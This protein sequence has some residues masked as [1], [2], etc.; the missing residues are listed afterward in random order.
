MWVLGRGARP[1]V[2]AGARAQS[3]ALP[4]VWG[5][6]AGGCSATGHGAGKGR[7]S[8]AAAGAPPRRV[9][10]PA[11][12]R[13]GHGPGRVLRRG[14]GALARAGAPPRGAC[15]GKG[16]H[17]GAAAGAPH[18]RVGAPA[19][20]EGT[21]WGTQW[22]PDVCARVGLHGPRRYAVFF[23]LATER[24]NKFAINLKPTVLNSAMVTIA[25]SHPRFL[26]SKHPGGI[27]CMFADI[28][29]N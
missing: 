24:L 14:R 8:G 22:S 2:R 26:G 23:L 12:R 3:G 18:R 13:K 20:G 9:G 11:G 28:F 15:A 29:L 19:G 25:H 16:R 10:V 17:S 5:S 6:G 1:P 27:F 21:N 7:R 4:R